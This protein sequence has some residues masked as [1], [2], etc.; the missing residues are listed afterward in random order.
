MNCAMFNVSKVRSILDKLLYGE[1]YDTIDEELSDCNIGGRKGRNIRDHLFVVYSVINDV[2]NGSSPPINIQTLDIY[3]CFDEM[4][5]AETH[6]D[7]YDVKVQDKK[8]ALI[9]KLDEEADVI[10]KTPCGP[11]E[12][13]KLRELVMQVFLHQSSQLFKLTLLEEIVYNTIKDYLS[14]KMC[15]V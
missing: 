1:E 13:F 15:S 11:T 7:L 8:F 3:K 4:W 6:N 2:I 12:E 9:A 5:Y 10:V 14:T